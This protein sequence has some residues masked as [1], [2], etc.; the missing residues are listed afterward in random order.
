MS[1]FQN[2]G[3]RY[4]LNVDT[5][6][7]VCI[8]IAVI[9]CIYTAKQRSSKFTLKNVENVMVNGKFP[10]KHGIHHAKKSKKRFHKS[11]E[12][13]RE[14]FQDIYGLPFKSVRPNWLK[15][16]ATKK[17]L[18]LDGFCSTIRTPF[19]FGIAFEYDGVQH[20]KYNKHFHKSGEVEFIYQRR[21]DDWK[22]KRCNEEGVT[23][24]R[25]P[26]FVEYNDLE[27]YITNKLDKQKL[28]PVNRPLKSQ[29]NTSSNGE[30]V[31]SMY[32]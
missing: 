1:T 11:E 7:A 6:A 13:C 16:P 32:G 27:R 10:W 22:D 30:N 25:I 4:F 2:K 3:W 18:E 14:I 8:I 28:L 24:I 20:A 15:N 31:K 26:H 17:N 29:Y 9:Y 19:G 21:K 12:K 5:I 23:L